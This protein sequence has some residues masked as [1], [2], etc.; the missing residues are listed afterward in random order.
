MTWSFNFI[1]YSTV[2]SWLEQTENFGPMISFEIIWR[3]VKL[4]KVLNM[5]LHS[6][7]S[8]FG[9]NLCENCVK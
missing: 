5:P 4:V 3:V 1:I 8:D 7:S 6:K 9:N 2:V